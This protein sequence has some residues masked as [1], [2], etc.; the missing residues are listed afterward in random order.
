[1]TQSVSLLLTLLCVAMIAAGQI[2]FKIVAIRGVQ[3]A[4]NGLFAQWLNWP[5]FA[6]LAIYGLATLL[7]IWVLRFVPLNIAY[8]M[9]ALAFIIVPV[10]SY[11]VFNETLGMRHLIGGGLILVGVLVIASGGKT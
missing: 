1:M 9:F 5:F 10:A 11:Y 6:A 3:E 8:P 4:G 2:L 7:W